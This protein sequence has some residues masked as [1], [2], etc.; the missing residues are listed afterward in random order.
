MRAQPS[1][2]LLQFLSAYLTPA[3]GQ[4]LGHASTVTETGIGRQLF[5]WLF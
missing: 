3:N 5:L 4:G 1:S 2:N